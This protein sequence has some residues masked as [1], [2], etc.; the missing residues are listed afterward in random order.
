[1]ENVILEHNL[2]NITLPE[3]AKYRE[4]I[5]CKAGSCIITCNGKEYLIGRN[6]CAVI[7]TRFIRNVKPSPDF[8]C[9][10]I[11]IDFNFLRQ[12]EPNN[13]FIIQATLMLSSDPIIR[14]SDPKEEELCRE[15][16]KNFGLRIDDK[17]HKFYDEILRTSAR[18]L[19]LDLFDMLARTR[20]VESP[21]AGTT[22]I[23]T[24]FINMLQ[25]KEYRDNREVAYYADKLGVVP[26]YLSEI[27][28]KTSGFSASYWINRFTAFD[29]NQLLHENR[30]SSNDIAELFHFSSTSYF[31]RYVKRYL[32]VYP[33]E[34]R[35]Q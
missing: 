25:D 13:P 10:V 26:K 28:N 5:F 27:S 29:I 19:A 18:M 24:R 22:D 3:R 21:S 8:D 1:M 11:Y 2:D 30:L 33:S 12:S 16:F 7:I 9:D 23:M 20:T 6:C 31:N 32:G 15:L 17:R 35:G 4:F 14:L 34:L